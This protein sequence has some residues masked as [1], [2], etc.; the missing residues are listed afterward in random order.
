MKISDARDVDVMDSA[1]S[2]TIV[3]VCIASR[4]RV[5]K[6]GMGGADTGRGRARGID[7]ELDVAEVGCGCGEVNLVRM[8]RGI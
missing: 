5:G 4:W 7:R 3:G 1:S 6:D 8:K 2:G